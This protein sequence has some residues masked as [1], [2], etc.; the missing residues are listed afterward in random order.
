MSNHDKKKWGI[1]FFAAI[2]VSV[3]MMVI[4]SF[5]DGGGTISNSDALFLVWYLMIQIYQ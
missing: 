2:M 4:F 5:N 3:I 1:I